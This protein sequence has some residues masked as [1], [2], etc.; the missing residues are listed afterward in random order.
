MQPPQPNTLDSLLERRR[1][2]YLRRRLFSPRPLAPWEKEQI[3]NELEKAI[4]EHR[5]VFPS[6]CR[7]QYRE[8]SQE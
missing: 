6:A 4:E 3:A 2:Y 5:P 8:S 7:I 1:L